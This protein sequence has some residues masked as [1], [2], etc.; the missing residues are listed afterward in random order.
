MRLLGDIKVGTYLR[1][2]H[3]RI[4]KP[5]CRTCNLTLKLAHLL[6]CLNLALNNSGNSS[7]ASVHHT[8]L[9][10]DATTGIQIPTGLNK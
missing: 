9:F 7:S 1:L 2:L 6:I 3:P 8:K 5:M 10:L 4:K